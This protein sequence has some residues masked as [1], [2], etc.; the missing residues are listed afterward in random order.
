[1]KDVTQMLNAVEQGDPHAASRVLPLVGRSRRS[2][3]VQK[4]GY[5]SSV[6]SSVTQR[7]DFRRNLEGDR[8]SCRCVRFLPAV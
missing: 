4:T 2:A 3:P 1:M 8:V 6:T 7:F 5:V